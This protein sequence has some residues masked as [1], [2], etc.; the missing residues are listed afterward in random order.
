MTIVQS[1]VIIAVQFVPVRCSV[2]QGVAGCCSVLQDVA[3]RCNVASR[4]HIH[5]M[6]DSAQRTAITQCN[7][8]VLPDRTTPP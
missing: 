4:I 5:R 7:T 1:L 2:S 3:A 6:Q 8:Q